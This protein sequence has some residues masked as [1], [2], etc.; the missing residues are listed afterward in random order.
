[1]EKFQE[2]TGH[3]RQENVKREVYG[4]EFMEVEDLLKQRQLMFVGRAGHSRN[5]LVDMF[6][7]RPEVRHENSVTLEYHKDVYALDLRSLYEIGKFVE[8][9]MW[10]CFFFF[11]SCFSSSTL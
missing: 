10:I 7:L 5:S 11:F 9:T 2:R 8:L 1:M 4:D 6:L 3:V